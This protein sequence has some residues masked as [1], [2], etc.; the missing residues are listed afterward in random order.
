MTIIQEQTQD[1]KRKAL[2]FNLRNFADI[3]ERATNC[4]IGEFT[5]TLSRKTTRDFSEPY[6]VQIYTLDDVDFTITAEGTFINN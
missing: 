5:F 1:E 2:I 3:I 4:E 6:D